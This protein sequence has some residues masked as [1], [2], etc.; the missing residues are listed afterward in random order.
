MIVA[1][2]VSMSVIA[3]LFLYLWHDE[4]RRRGAVEK[5]MADEQEIRTA[6]QMNSDNLRI[7]VD[8]SSAQTVVLEERLFEEQLNAD[9]MRI[10]NDILEG[11]IK[12]VED[13]LESMTKNRN[14]W[15]T[16]TRKLEPLFFSAAFASGQETARS[17][18]LREEIDILRPQIDALAALL[19]SCEDEKR[20]REL[21]HEVLQLVSKLS[22][23]GPTGLAST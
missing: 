8:R 4:C 10:K 16:Y 18:V 9:F 23:R 21:L 13:S 1:Y 5:S 20:W 3:A 14:E 22:L 15:V 7:E 12:A 19:V 6:E 11:V 2:A 17:A